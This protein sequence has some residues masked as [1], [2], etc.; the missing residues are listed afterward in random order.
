MRKSHLTTKAPFDVAQARLRTRRVRITK[1]PNFVP[2]VSFVVK[3]SFP[4]GCC[5]A[6]LGSFDFAQDRP[7]WLVFFVTQHRAAAAARTAQAGV[8]AFGFLRVLL[9][10]L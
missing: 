4:F 8:F 2:F 3:N 5:I 1:T 9:A 6:A 7:L 10:D